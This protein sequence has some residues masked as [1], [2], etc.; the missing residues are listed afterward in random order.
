[1]VWK[2]VNCLEGDINLDEYIL[3][4]V[5]LRLFSLFNIG[6]VKVLREGIDYRFDGSRVVVD[7]RYKGRDLEFYFYKVLG[8]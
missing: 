2:I 8:C 3:D 7:E 6:V 5:E 4:R 1:M